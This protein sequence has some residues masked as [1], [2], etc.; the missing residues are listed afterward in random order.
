MNL[1]PLQHMKNALCTNKFRLTT[2]LQRLVCATLITAA[3][4]SM[5]CLAAEPRILESN[6]GVRTVISGLEQPISMAFTGPD[7]LF[8]LEKGSGRVQQVVDGA[9]AATVLDLAVNS[10]SERGLL[11][12][13]LHPQFPANPGV[14]LYWTESSTGED[15]TVVS[16]TPLLGNRVDRFV[17]DGSTLTFDHNL[18]RIRA[19]QED[20]DQPAR[21]NHNGGVLRFGPDGKLYIYI[22]DVGRRGQMQNLPDGPGPAGNMA[23]DQFGGPEPD[24]AHLTGVI[25]RLNDDGSTPGDNPFF[26]AGASRGGEA[27]ANLQKVFAYGIRNG[28]GMAFDPFSGHLWEAQNGDDTFTE[29]NRVEPGANLGWIQIMGPV[30]RIDQ[31]KEIETS[32]EFFGL[33]QIRWEPTSIADT[34][35]EA[36]ARLFMV[37]EGGDEFGALM[38]G[39]QEVPPVMTGA[40]AMA[41]F[42]LN[43]DGTLSFDLI[44]TG[45]I[46]DATQAHIHL[47]ARGQNG[48]V[49]LFLY[50]LTDGENFAA[51]DLIASGTVGDADVIARPGFVPTIANLVERMRQGRAY[52]NLH[53]LAHPPGEVRGQIMVT[54]RDPVSHYSDPEFSWKFEVA[55][56]GVGFINSGALGPQYTGDMVVGAARTFLE[57]GHLFRLKLTG[58]RLKIAV[59]DPRLED[60]VADNLGKF[61]IT[62]S[63]SLLFGTGFGI[64]TDIQ[65]GPNGNLF[66][67]SLSNGAIYE[68]FRDRPG[69]GVPFLNGPPG[70]GR[71]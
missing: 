12:I 61:D 50:G 21:G 1:E 45:P 6:L 63:E 37:F 40:G 48:P 36:L 11:G 38:T 14:Y 30:G 34:P 47:G 64:G 5:V 13:A 42:E 60:R 16:E 58:N 59:D 41:L 54:D 46:Q 29:I 4:S 44:A 33:Q 43:S 28:F 32:E 35:D 52:A 17:W 15:T 22:G 9:I 26:G 20:A 19:I 24:D 57:E 23:D 10:A 18:I 71:R 69:R 27:G 49:V 8:V 55:P 51:G 56:A 65:T 70:R 2:G 3:C 7:E 68:I 62:E 25:L 66:V 31:F 67:V 39:S 53:T